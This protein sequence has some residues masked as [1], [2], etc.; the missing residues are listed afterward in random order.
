MIYKTESIVLPG[1]RV[2]LE[3]LPFEP[4]TLV[5]ITIS[6]KK[7]EPRS[8]AADSPVVP[9]ETSDALDVD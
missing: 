6:L 7:D 8:E 4:G 3:N 1:G 2:I 9:S 5:S